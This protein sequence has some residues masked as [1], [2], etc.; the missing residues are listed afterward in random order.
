MPY[1]L[2]TAPPLYSWTADGKDRLDASLATRARNANLGLGALARRDCRRS[3]GVQVHDGC[4]HQI[5]SLGPHTVLLA[6]Q[7]WGVRSFRAPGAYREAAKNPSSGAKAQ[8]S[9]IIYAV[10]EAP[11]S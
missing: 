4:T 3:G 2:A 7:L 10:A 9:C 8:S 5:V 6:D 11:A 1:H